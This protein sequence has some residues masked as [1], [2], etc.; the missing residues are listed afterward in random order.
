MSVFFLGVCVLL[1][2][3]GLGVVG[4][5]LR[6]VTP[7]DRMLSASLAGSL[8]M[9]LLLLLAVVAEVP[10]LVD[11]ALMLAVLGALA[12]SSFAARPQPREVRPQVVRER[13]R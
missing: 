8:L 13:V 7:V 2:V 10:M 12:V 9:A 1:L 5:W 11:V 3:T 4:R 6:A